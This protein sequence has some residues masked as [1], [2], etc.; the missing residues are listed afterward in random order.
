MPHNR[1]MLRYE[2]TNE[3][4]VCGVGLSEKQKR[5]KG[6]LCSDKCRTQRGKDIW[7]AQRDAIGEGWRYKVPCGTVGAIHE[8]VVSVALM[9]EGWHVF[10]ALSPACPCDLLIARKGETPLRIEI[11]TG[12]RGP[13]GN[14]TH[15]KGKVLNGPLPR[16]FDHI[17]VVLGQNEIIWLPGP[18]PAATPTPEQSERSS[19]L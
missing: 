16:A 8:L 17:A 15:P 14:V 13:A 4:I 3:C 1:P 7:I 18:P 12:F 11:T 2:G 6:K 10:R 9:K 5:R 19:D